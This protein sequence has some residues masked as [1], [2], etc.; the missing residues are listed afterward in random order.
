MAESAVLKHFSRDPGLKTALSVILGL[1]LF[2]LI[3]LLL[4]PLPLHADETQY[5]IWSQTFDFGYFSK[6]PLIAWVIALSTSLFG[7]SEA[8]VRL[9]VIFLHSGTASFI[10]LILRHIGA[11]RV[12]FWSAIVYLTMPAIW[13]S[14]GIMSTD[15]LLLCAW[16]G[17]LYALLRLRSEQTWPTGIALGVAIGLGFLAKYAMIYFVVG[18]GLAMVFDPLTRR[19]LLSLKGLAAGMLALAIFSPNIAWNAA[20]DFATVSHTAA[21]ANWGG[22]MFH[23]GEMLDFILGQFGILGPALFPLLVI[24]VWQVLRR[25]A[26]GLSGAVTETF[27]DPVDAHAGLLVGFVWPPIVIVSLQ[28]F[29]SRAHANWA[30]AAYVGGIIL[31]TAFLLRGPNWRRV[32]LLASIGVH[33]FLGLLGTV[34]IFSPG[35]T[36]WI[37]AENAFKR[38]RAWRET[39]T[40]V[41]EVSRAAPYTAVLFD[42]RNV[43]H[44]MQRYAPDLAAP[45][46]MWWR[47]S[48]PTNHAEREW[49]MP[50]GLEGDLLVISHRPLEVDRIRQD[51]RQMEAVDTLII[52]LGGEKVRELTVWRVNIHER[53]PR[54]TAYED[55]WLGVDAAKRAGEAPAILTPE[56]RAIGTGSEQPEPQRP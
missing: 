3:L 52:P 32:V 40:L 53:V 43:F 35:F 7:D 47:Y 6:P 9:P 34:M 11:P 27:A 4:S 37:G 39:G 36:E 44:Q 8:A 19:A 24:T 28:A 16:S 56:D 29:L 2:R 13:L 1:A 51:F 23:P 22:D 31:V 49:P 18:L 33:T 12:G 20:H 55:Y 48:G 15:T 14:A 54:D 5:W 46:Y 42:D 38:V 45:Q 21:N 25:L 10:L 17:A 30:A 26:A 50:D 41:E